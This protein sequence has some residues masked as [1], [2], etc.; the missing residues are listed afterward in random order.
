MNIGDRVLVRQPGQPERIGLVM[1]FDPPTG[2]PHH[3]YI[4]WVPRIDTPD[5]VMSVFRDWVEA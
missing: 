4:K 2:P 3:I 5:G 1:G